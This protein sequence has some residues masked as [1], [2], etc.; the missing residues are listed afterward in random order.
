M[1]EYLMNYYSAF[2]FIGISHILGILNSILINR[3][4]YGRIIMLISIILLG[5]GVCIYT[6]NYNMFMFAIIGSVALLSI[7]KYINYNVSMISILAISA[8]CELYHLKYSQ[9]L[10][11]WQISILIIRI[12]MSLFIKNNEDNKHHN[13][14]TS[15]LYII[16]ILTI[17]FHAIN[18]FNNNISMVLS[19]SICDWKHAMAL[20]AISYISY[21]GIF[22]MTNH[23]QSSHTSHNKK[24]FLLISSLGGMIGIVST[25]Y[26]LLIIPIFIHIILKGIKFI[27]KLFNKSTNIIENIIQYLFSNLAY[28]IYMFISICA[29]LLYYVNLI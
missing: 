22:T 19:Y 4:S 1:Q 13:I 29:G 18:S 21:Y 20:M 12:I 26:L 11:P 17:V 28:I 3:I 8:V 23:L 16:P 10:N 15:S 14:S 25:K 5:L 9:L 2:L 27:F 6:S 7:S 24:L